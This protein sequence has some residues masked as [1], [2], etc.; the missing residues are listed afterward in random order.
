M[1]IGHV[2][3]ALGARGVVRSAPL[4]LLLLAAQACDWVELLVSWVAPYRDASTWSHSWLAVGIGTL[5]FGA[6]AFRLTHSLSGWAACSLTYLAHAPADYLTGL[7]PT[8]PG[9]PKAGLLLY[10]RP[11]TDFAVEITIVLVGWILYCR[12]L[13]PGA[14]LRWPA[15]ATL[16]LLAALQG[17]ADVVF[18]RGGRLLRDGPIGPARAVVL[19]SVVPAPWTEARR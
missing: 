13:P 6:L 10:D 14:P 15:W 2:G 17:T 11:V 19:P 3:I 4:W 5:L 7:K 1:Y 12:S 8:W 16:A 9:G 18:A